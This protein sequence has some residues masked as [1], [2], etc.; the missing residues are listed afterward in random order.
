MI[1]VDEKLGDYAANLQWFIMFMQ[2]QI[3]KAIEIWLNLYTYIYTLDG[4][5]NV[6]ITT[7]LQQG[8]IP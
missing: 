5:K 2:H 1:Y 4:R 6:M 7:L 3:Q 8:C